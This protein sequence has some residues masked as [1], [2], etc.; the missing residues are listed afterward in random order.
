MNTRNRPISK[1]KK[2]AA[3]EN[4]RLISHLL[5]GGFDFLN[6]AN[7][8]G[9]PAQFTDVIELR[10]SNTTVAHDFDFVDNPRMHWEDALDAVAEGNLTNRKR[11]PIAAVFECDTD[12]FKDLDA[13]LVAFLD[14]DVNLDRIS[15][16]EGRKVGSQLFLFDRIQ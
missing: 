7:S 8:G 10:A 14:F 6:F 3:I 11:R 16:V 5:S 12:A 13:F 1:Q 4:N 9:L 2:I 15:R